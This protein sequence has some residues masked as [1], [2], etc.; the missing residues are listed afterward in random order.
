MCDY[1]INF[2]KCIYN[3]DFNKTFKVIYKYHN[4][5]INILDD[6]IDNEEDFLTFEVDNVQFNV[7]NTE[8]FRAKNSKKTKIGLSLIIYINNIYDTIELEN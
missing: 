7:K 8:V 2:D 6:I 3:N 1:R 4:L 5:I